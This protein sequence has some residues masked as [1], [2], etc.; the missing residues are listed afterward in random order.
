[1]IRTPALAPP[2]IPVVKRKKIRTGRGPDWAV[3]RR[4]SSPQALRFRTI[5]VRSK[6]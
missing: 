2:S 1:M 6:D 4:P 3:P 5:Q